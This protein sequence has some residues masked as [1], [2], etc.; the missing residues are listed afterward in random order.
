MTKRIRGKTVRT[1]D[2]K[3]NG[4]KMVTIRTLGQAGMQKSTREDPKKI[5]KWHQK[6]GKPKIVK[7]MVAGGGIKGMVENPI[8]SFDM[9][10]IMLEDGPNNPYGVDEDI[11]EVFMSEQKRGS[12]KGSS[13]KGK[14]ARR[15]KG[16]KLPVE[17][18][19]G[20]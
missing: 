17:P 8:T 18:W 7:K 2:E 12:H 10:N 1:S 16:T 3:E 9:S 15:K 14:G 6:D 13:K 11:Y 19:S 5:P 20:Y 4:Y